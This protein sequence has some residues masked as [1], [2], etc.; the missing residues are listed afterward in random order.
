MRAPVRLRGD[1]PPVALETLS[2]PGA[3]LPANLQAALGLAVRFNSI[4][5]STD[6]QT[7]IAG[8]QVAVDVLPGRHAETLSRAVLEQTEFHAGDT[9]TVAATVKPY[10]GEERQVRIPVKLPAALPEGEVRVLVSDGPALDRAIAAGRGGSPP[11]TGTLD[12]LNALHDDDRLYVTLLRP[13]AGMTVEGRALDAL[14]L[15]VANR[16]LPAHAQDKG[17]LHNES[18]DTLASVGLDANFQGEQVLTL[19]IS[20]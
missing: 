18:I 17:S 10:R 7:G 3:G 1:Y 14:P 4:Y 5:S 15:S 19:H 11:L 2:T 16:L 13:D 6:R 12:Q 8:I 9:V 20:E